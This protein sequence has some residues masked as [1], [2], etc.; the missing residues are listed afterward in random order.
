MSRTRHLPGNR[1]A[2]TSDGLARLRRAWV[3]AAAATAAA[4][5]PAHGGDDGP[6]DVTRPYAE[7][8]V[9]SAV[10]IDMVPIPRG[11]LAARAGGRET[12]VGPLWMSRT[13]IPWEVY[14]VFAYRLDQPDA[15]AAGADAV[16]RPSKPYLPP[17][18]GFGHKGY[19]AISMTHEA[20]REFC[21]WLSA[22]TGR[23]YR[24]PTEAEW[25]FACR[26]GAAGAY[27]IGDDAGRLGEVAW[28]KANAGGKPRAIAGKK[29][30]AWG[31]YDMHGNVAEWCDGADGRGVACGGTY[32]DGPEKLR[33]DAR[34]H[35]EASWNASDPQVPKSRWWLA[36][37]GFVGFRIVCEP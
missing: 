3:A 6:R 30:N 14:D 29:A 12:A 26:A 36:D 18:R 7:K 4:V 1:N 28:Y 25:E 17:D 31:L 33:C 24:L 20:A 35:Q 8:I 10:A 19:A 5:A 32:L 11:V 21:K 34:M 37:C 2:R 9:G 15:S 23:K 16:S 27:S 22:K 13:E